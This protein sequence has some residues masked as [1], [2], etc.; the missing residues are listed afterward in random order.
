MDIE[1]AEFI[2]NKIGKCIRKIQLY[3]SSPTAN[4]IHMIYG[5]QTQ[6]L[7]VDASRF[8]PVRTLVDI[9]RDPYILMCELSSFRYEYYD[10]PYDEGIWYSKEDREMDRGLQYLNYVKS[11]Y[12][13]ENIGSIYKSINMK[14]KSK[15]EL[16][17]IARD[18][19]CVV[20]K[21]WNKRQIMRAIYPNLKFC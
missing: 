3:L 7:Q 1:T 15:K 16:L 8:C 11:F 2:Q 17:D 9:D 18:L 10:D 5:L 19:G 6:Y 13:Y 12:S 4:I 20:Y 21:S 14:K